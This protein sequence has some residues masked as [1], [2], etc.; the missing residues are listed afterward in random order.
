MRVCMY[1]LMYN[2]CVARHKKK[3]G[4][5]SLWRSL[6]LLEARIGTVRD[7]RALS[8]PRITARALRSVFTMKR[9]RRN[10]EKALNVR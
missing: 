8:E 2:V 3:K 4:R 7:K 5:E 1:L 6:R 9:F 10:K